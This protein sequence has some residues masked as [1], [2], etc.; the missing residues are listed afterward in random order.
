MREQ[1]AVL[2]L[3]AAEKIME[4]ELTVNG[5]DAD[6]RTGFRGSRCI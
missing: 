6:H 3:M 1:I 2:S 4:R 5:Q